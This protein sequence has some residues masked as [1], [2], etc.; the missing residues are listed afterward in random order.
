[1]EDGGLPA[2]VFPDGARDAYGCIGLLDFIR[3]TQDCEIVLPDGGMCFIAG[4]EIRDKHGHKLDG[5]HDPAG[6]HG[7]NHRDTPEWKAEHPRRKEHKMAEHHDETTTSMT[8]IPVLLAS[9]DTLPAQAAPSAP[10]ATTATVGVD[11][12]V[13]QVKALLPAGADA[14]PGLLIGG[15]AGLAVVGA[16]VKFGPGLMKARAER[17]AQEKEQAHE[18]KMK[19]LEIEQQK[20]DQQK[21]DDSHGKCSVERAMLEAKVA[22]QAA[23]LVSLTEKLAEIAA[24][25]EKIAATPPPP[26][27]DF[28]IE[29]LEERLA[30]IEKALPKPAKPAKKGAK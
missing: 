4:Q 27:L 7:C 22:A 10:A 20:A 6:A 12:A 26:E 16:A 24:K 30:K 25:A 11:Q 1:M 2:C 28:D 9:T 29:A 18:E 3:Y 17:L 19:Q 23:Q 14:S 15:A 13:A 8:P 5:D 21:Q